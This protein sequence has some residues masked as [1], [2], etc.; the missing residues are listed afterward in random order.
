MIERRREQAPK[1]SP[2]TNLKSLWVFAA[3]LLVPLPLVIA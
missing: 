3:V 2:Y 1:H